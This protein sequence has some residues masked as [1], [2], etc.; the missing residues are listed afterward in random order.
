MSESVQ[1]YIE[2]FRYS[3][4]YIN[5]HRNKV[6]VILITGEALADG[7]FP[8]IVYDVSLLNSL[9]V[10]L[11]LVHGARPQISA[12]LQQAGIESRYHRN[13][14]ISDPA[15]LGAIKDTVGHLS[16]DI[17]AQFSLGLINSP[18]HG[19]DIRLC[20]G[21]FI[22]ARP[23]GIHDGIDFCNTG[24]VRKVQK[25]AIESQL[26]QGNI[27]L[28]SNLGYSTTGEVFNLSAEEVAM[29]TAT[30]LAADKLI[31]F[32]PGQGVMNSEEA[33]IHSMSP[34]SARDYLQANEQSQDKQ[35]RVT[36]DALSA[37][38]KASE[39]GVPRVHLISHQQNGALLQELF[40][41]E[42]NGTLISND[43]FEELRQAGIDDVGGILELI[44]PLEQAGTLV[45]RSREL[46][47][48][49]VTNFKVVAWEGML[50]ACA[51]LY[52]L[53][54]ASGEIACIAIHSDY[55]NRGLGKRLLTSLEK[56]ARTRGLE[57]V[58]ILTTAATHWFLE[59]GFRLSSVDELPE[60]K[61]Q[62]YNYQRNSKVLVKTL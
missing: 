7:N 19:S 61:K 30:A 56:E 15:S 28:L 4:A 53:E 42:G 58:F 5:A 45:Q 12:A 36:N 29:K 35:Q 50:I 31:L 57:R 10:K 13:L 38:L 25:K 9:G 41:R 33:L 21:N 32:I 26:S 1:Q 52:P 34:N 20:R 60:S 51:A 14:R 62:L 22:T 46:L 47:E 2:W 43:S 18:M 44:K 6:F 11:V 48:T 16:I 37:A 8:N 40:T 23:Y 54:N 24:L 3:S 49:E 27:V 17:E 59:N 39:G 55:Q